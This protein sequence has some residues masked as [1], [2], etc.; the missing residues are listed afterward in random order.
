VT[1]APYAAPP[2]G[3][4]RT[5]DHRYYWNGEGPLPGVTTVVGVMDKPALV[6]WA[7]REVAA[8]AVRN[9]REL[10]RL[11]EADPAE[12]QRWLS[13]IPDYISGRAAELGT[14]VHWHAEQVALGQ[15]AAFAEADPAWP[16]VRQYLDWRDDWQPVYLE[17]EYRG[18]SLAHRYGGTGDLIVQDRSGTRW[19]LDIKTGG[20][21][22]E[23]VLQL[24]ACSRFDFL[25]DE[26]SDAKRPVPE[27][28][29]F[30]VLDLKADGWKVV[31]YRAE[32]QETFEA[33]AA[34]A[35]VWHWKR[36]LRGVRGEAWTG[37]ASEEAA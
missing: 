22:D 27:V 30:G 37:S 28:E 14:L 17:V 19:L 13:T 15:Q 26:G 33:F 35:R 24:V 34:L 21:Y 29:R 12:A 20:Y 2:V 6:G 4:H 32:P 25:G 36:G 8:C 7:K 23:T 3:L 10:G 16:F 18:V 9:H 31:P 5:E 1:R 11:I